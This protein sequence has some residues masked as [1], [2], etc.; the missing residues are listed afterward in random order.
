MDVLMGGFLVLVSIA[1]PPA[2]AQ[3]A[4]KSAPK[5]PAEYHPDQVAGFVRD[6]AQAKGF[7][8]LEVVV[9]HQ[10][11]PSLAV[12]CGATALQGGRPITPEIPLAIGSVSKQFT[13]A[14][15][16][17][18]AQDGKL[19]PTD[20]VSRWY[21]QATQADRVTLL[22]LMNHTSG[23]TDYYPLDFVDRRMAKP[24]GTDAL[25]QRYAGGK[26][27]FEP[28]AKYSYSNTG[29]TIL[30][31]VVERVSGQP[32]G[33]FLRER[34]FKPLD[35]AT[36]RY[37]PPHDATGLAT[38][39]RALG[40]DGSEPA[41]PEGDGWLNGAG[42][43]WA[44]ATD[45][46]KWAS[47]LMGGKALAPPSLE[48]MTRPRLLNNG[49]KSYYGCGLTVRESGGEPV[50]G[51]TG[52]ISGF[53]A[54]LTMMPRTKTVVI[55]L[56]NAEHL[57][58]GKLHRDIVTLLQKEPANLP[59]VNGPKAVDQ[60]KSLV[61]QLARGML[62]PDNLGEEYALFMN[63]GRMQAYTRKLTE[64]GEPTAVLVSSQHERGGT[65]VSMLRLHFKNGVNLLGS[66]YRTPDGKVQ[67]FLLTLE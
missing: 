42:G 8:G 39:Y 23:Y 56:A 66:L 35:M 27:D 12:G 13:C 49:K 15:I 50:W 63:P 28:G 34:I 64:L 26:L 22:D 60:A 45:L 20:K 51:H 32:L 48:I 7:I 19:S 14:A 47:A 61:A 58:D 18:L 17:L 3:P 2:P 41:P 54:N 6:T 36:A 52:S 11:K 37:E 59:R 53:H 4:E 62:E 40:I 9:V 55:T 65:E 57:D 30:G 29:Y 1:Q 44:S 10:G 5:A 31:R 16:L 46:A 25:I 33:D 43:V 38:G 67:Q 24:T 21:P